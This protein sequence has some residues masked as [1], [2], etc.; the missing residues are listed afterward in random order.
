MSGT[1]AAQEKYNKSKAA[2][3]WTSDITSE[4]ST[5]YG[6]TLPYVYLGTTSPY[7]TYD[8]G[9]GGNEIMCIWVMQRMIKF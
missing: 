9:R 4:I 1:V 3:D 8:E 7:F 2:S 6:L 5:K